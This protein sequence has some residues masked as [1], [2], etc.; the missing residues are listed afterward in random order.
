MRRSVLF[1]ALSTV[2]LTGCPE[3]DNFGRLDFDAGPPADAGPAPNDLPINVGDSFLYQGISRTPNGC[4]DG[5]IDEQC[6]EQGNWYLNLE[7]TDKVPDKASSVTDGDSCGDGAT[8]VE[9]TRD[10]CAVCPGDDVPTLLNGSF[11]INGNQGP[12]Q[13]YCI[14]ARGWDNVYQL[15]A[16]SG[17]D[18]QPEHPRPTNLS[19]AWVYNL[20]PWDNAQK[21]PFEGEKTYRTNVAAL[22]RSSKQPF[23]WALDLSKWQVVS[24]EFVDHVLSVDPDADIQRPEGG[25]YMRAIMNYELNGVTVRHVVEVLYHE[26]GYLCK[27]DEKLGPPSPNQ[28]D[29][30]QLGEDGA[31][32]IYITVKQDPETLA[33]VDTIDGNAECL[34]RDECPAGTSCRAGRCKRI[35]PKCC[36]PGTLNCR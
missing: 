9:P 30:V 12:A 29:T 17:Y 10:R 15:S 36:T 19:P 31:L 25:A 26:K 23:P 16:T 22:P 24:Q 33:G 18:I 3:D 28:S 2:V 27:Y 1:V 8:L 6:E 21:G 34:S 7:V 14:P 32:T 20:A 5:F 4:V 11:D 13:V 35:L